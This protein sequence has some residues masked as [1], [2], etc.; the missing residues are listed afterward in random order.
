MVS[1][2]NGDGGPT[3][4][5]AF[6]GLVEETPFHF[7]RPSGLTSAASCM[8]QPGHSGRSHLPAEPLA[9]ARRRGDRTDRQTPGFFAAASNSAAKFAAVLRPRRVDF[10][11]NSDVLSV[12]EGINRGD[13]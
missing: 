9:H 11:E 4:P 5:N 3:L 12:V 7:V 6:T 10:A 1:L 8:P 2:E 13:P